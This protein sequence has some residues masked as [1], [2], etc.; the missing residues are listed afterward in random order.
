[1]MSGKPVTKLRSENMLSFLPSSLLPS[2][3]P[4]SLLPP[5]IPTYVPPSLPS[6]LIPPSLPPPFTYSKRLHCLGNPLT[7]LR[8]ENIPMACSPPR[9][10]AMDVN[11]MLAMCWG[12]GASLHVSIQNGRY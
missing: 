6:S 8:A 12:G 4:P 9:P 3:P 10:T 2:L 7:R 5:S 11:T 1:M